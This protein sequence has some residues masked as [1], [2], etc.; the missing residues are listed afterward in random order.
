MI[1]HRNCG[2]EKL[3]ESIEEEANREKEDGQPDPGLCCIR[4][5]AD[6]N[7]RG[8][9]LNAAEGDVDQKYSQHNGSAE[10]RADE[11]RRG[12]DSGEFAGH[13]Q[14]TRTEMRH[15]DRRYDQE[16]VRHAA[17]KQK[18]SAQKEKQHDASLD[19]KVPKR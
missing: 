5:I 3:L 7:R 18:M 2:C 4:V 10:L 12:A 8:D 11:Y 6:A 16:A 13:R 14:P 19:L 17:Q 9:F 15:L 1:D